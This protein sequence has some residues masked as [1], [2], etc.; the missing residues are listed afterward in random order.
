[1][2]GKALLSAS[3]SAAPAV[4][5]VEDV[6]STYLYTGNSSTQTITNGIDLAG[7]GGMVWIKSRND[8]ID[9]RLVD[10]QRTPFSTLYSNSSGAES[11][12]GLSEVS[13]FNSNGFTVESSFG[14]N[15]SSY[16]Y[17]SWT[18]RKAPRFFDVVTYA[19]NGVSGRAIPHNLGT[20][21]GMII[22]KWYDGSQNWA[23]WHR[24]LTAGKFLILNG[25]N[26]ENTN[27]TI[28]TTT[29]PTSTE[30]YV[31]SDYASNGTGANY[32]AY[33][34]AHDPLGPSGDGSD[35][36]I[37]CGSFTTDGSGNATVDLGW[38]P[39]FVLWK[40]SNSSADWNIYDS[41]R[42]FVAS[43]S[44]GQRLRPNTSSAEFSDSQLRP[45]ATG[46]NG[47]G[48]GG[49]GAAYNVIYIAIR[50]G[51]MRAPESGTEV[52]AMDNPQS[53]QTDP[54]FI[55]G[56]PVDLGIFKLKSSVTSWYWTNRVAGE[57]RYLESDTTTAEQVT[58]S[59]AMD[60]NNGWWDGINNTGAMSW[61]FRRA[62]G[63]FDVV[64]YTGTGSARTV[65]HS[66]TVAPELIFV[67]RRN[68][69]G[70]WFTYNATAGNTYYLLLNSTSA[71]D[72][73][74]TYWNSTT[75]TSS[76]FSLGVETNLNG[77]G[78]TFVAYLF[79]TCPGVSKVGSYTG[80][81]TTLSIDCG[82]TAG[83]RFV[84]IK[85]TDSTGD[86]YVWDTTR[87]II[88]GN[89][90]YLLF[91]SAAAE[92]TNTDYIDPLSSGFQISSTAPAAIN[93]SGGTY[94]FLAIA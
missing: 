63:F 49:G 21:V 58:S 79:A 30:F 55:S 72:G 1:M 22:V 44:G 52:F 76:V 24:T 93:A 70:N 64:A 31:G 20:D 33:L 78:G 84:L 10:S 35:G 92:V 45:S 43:A 29:A 14:T 82:F 87:G 17:A 42:G 83:A 34:F 91:N 68:N 54:G 38:E 62:P 11:A 26:A 61:M 32:V 6:F 66:L 77:S 89:D 19:G 90:P 59:A 85:R 13:S 67:K 4:Y 86:W 94:I 23:V 12:S 2:L 56:F 73:P 71:K 7:E 88:A 37:D 28:F 18:F 50:R 46:F 27:S 81:G 15:N 5:Y 51:P 60:Y 25:T 47:V 48:V 36:L 75:P 57:G 8:A 41:M 39:Q 40:I 65:A 3:V 80:T 53:L 16:T 74:G 9:H 69:S